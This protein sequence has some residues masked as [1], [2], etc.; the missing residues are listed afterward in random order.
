M[1]AKPTL[2]SMSARS[3]FESKPLPH[4]DYGF[5]QERQEMFGS[6]GFGALTG[7][8]QEGHIVSTCINGR[9]ELA[10]VRA[11]GESHLLTLKASDRFLASLVDLDESAVD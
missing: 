1:Q 11:F 8:E 9:G 10:V 4:V 3:L 6:A 2:L 7:D 5:G